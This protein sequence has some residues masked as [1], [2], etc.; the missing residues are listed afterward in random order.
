MGRNG[1]GLVQDYTERRRGGASRGRVRSAEPWEIRGGAWRLHMS[2]WGWLGQLQG[3]TQTFPWNGHDVRM[4]SMFCG[5][6]AMR[7]N[8]LMVDCNEKLCW[9]SLCW[10]GA[11]GLFLLLINCVHDPTGRHPKYF[12]QFVY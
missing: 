3:L 11:L 8:V 12:V 2:S 1:G 7:R 9:R 5:A 10:A 6:P 4:E